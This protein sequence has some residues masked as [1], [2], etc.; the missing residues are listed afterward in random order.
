MNNKMVWPLSLF[1]LLL[2]TSQNCFAGEDGFGSSGGGLGG[3]TGGFPG[4]TTGGLTGGITGGVTAGTTGGQTNGTTG[5]VTGGTTGGA[6]DAGP[7]DSWTVRTSP[8]ANTL[9]VVT[10]GNG[11]FVAVG[12]G[13]TVVTS[14]DGVTWTQRSSGTT[15][16]IYGVIFGNNLYVAVGAEGLVMTSPD[17]ITW[18]MQTS[19]TQAILYTVAYGKGR[20]VAVGDGVLTSTDGV[21]WNFKGFSNTGE[22]IAS[23]AQAGGLQANFFPFPFPS[24][25]TYH[26]AGVSFVN[27]QFLAV[28]YIAQSDFFFF[29][30]YPKI[31]TSTDGVTWVSRGAPGSTFGLSD[32]IYGNG[33]FV[34]V[35]GSGAVLSS[36]DGSSWGARYPVSLGLNSV[37]FAQG[38]FVVVGESGMITSSQ[39]GFNWTSRQSANTRT[40]YEITFGNDSF[41]AVG[42]GGVILQSGSFAPVPVELGYSRS[43]NQMILSWNAAGY[44]LQESSTTG[45]SAT[46]TVAAGGNA[47]PV[48]VTN[49][50]GAKFF[51]LQKL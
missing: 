31:M 32:G 38:L 7:L 48:T 4:L 26:L 15:K 34:T 1:L 49:G 44:V 37:A 16:D 24:A 6:I 28:G 27:N 3:L 23:S 45:D 10:Y 33:T 40:L 25:A 21:H 17:A 50:G 43:G 20:Y 19:G 29:T 5:G 11:Q 2:S 13:G 47:S 22:L 14:P 51:R 35:G 30:Y 9:S 18:T 8:T 39:D 36:S 12:V 46:W 41:V 42:E